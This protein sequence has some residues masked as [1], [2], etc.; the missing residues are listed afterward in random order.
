MTDIPIEELGRLIV[1]KRGA[2]GVRAAAAQVG[3]GAATLWRVENGQMPDLQT[4]AKI[5]RWLELDP[6]DFLGLRFGSAPTPTAVVHFRKSKTVSLETARSLAELILST[7][8]SARA[9]ERLAR[10]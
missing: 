5:C 8:R 7:Q 10:R 2:L 1:A 3:I 4:F 9:R 6:A